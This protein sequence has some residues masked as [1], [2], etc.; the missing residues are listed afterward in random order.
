MR[1]LAAQR[2]AWPDTH[3]WSTPAPSPPRPSARR[4]RRSAARARDNPDA[5]IIV[6]GCAAQIAPGGLGRPARRRA[7]HRQRRQ[8]EARDLGALDAPPAPV[9]DIMAATRDGGA[10][11]HRLRRPRARLRA[12]AAGLR[13]SLHLLRHP[14][15]PRPLALACRS[16]RSWSRC[17]RWSTRGYREVVLTG[18]DITSYGPDLP[19]APSARADGAAA[20]GA[21]AGAA[22]AAPV[23]ARPGRRSTTTSGA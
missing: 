13:P 8:A 15:R 2:R 19:G 7:R 3:R 9:S 10:P 12:G 6:T 5:R 17:A 16:A 18:V 21:G 11:G 1:D 22:A 4:A 20:A 14:L 23:L